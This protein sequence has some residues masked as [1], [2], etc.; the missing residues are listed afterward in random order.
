MDLPGF[1][2]VAAVEA[3][4]PKLNAG[5]G[6]EVVTA[7]PLPNDISLIEADSP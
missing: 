3:V 2:G 6:V 1:T 7:N 5:A 4:A